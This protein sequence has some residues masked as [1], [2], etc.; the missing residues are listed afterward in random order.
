MLRITTLIGETELRG[1]DEP[2]LR[3]RSTSPRAF[4]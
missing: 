3:D 2:E 4:G 1:A